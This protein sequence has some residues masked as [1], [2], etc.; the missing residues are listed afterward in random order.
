MRA[1]CKAKSAHRPTKQRLRCCGA[2]SARG[3]LET[4]FGRYTGTPCSLNHR[5][6]SPS[7]DDLCSVICNLPRQSEALFAS[8]KVKLGEDEYGELAGK[9]CDPLTDEGEW[10]AK[11][12][13]DVDE[14]RLVLIRHDNVGRCGIECETI[15]VACQDTLGEVDLDVAEL[16]WQRK[17]KRAKLTHEVCRQLT[18]ACP[19]PLSKVSRSRHNEDFLVM[20]DA[21]RDMAKL[22]QQMQGMPGMS[23]QLFDSGAAAA[24]ALKGSPSTLPL[25]AEGRAREPIVW[26]GVAAVDTAL[27]ALRDV[28]LAGR[29][30]L[31][32]VWEVPV[33]QVPWQTHEV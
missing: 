16:L 1:K 24:A 22:M 2:R 27:S 10:I 31:Y 5:P 8:S 18:D 6:P 14:G 30:W 11:L 13:V 23:P 32:R 7:A 29:D 21:D 17:L 19:G 4:S 9:I 26:S 12:D 33:R 25:T 15:K 28:V 20:S 3:P